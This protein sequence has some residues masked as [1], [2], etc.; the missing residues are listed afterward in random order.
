MKGPG[1]RLAIDV[2]RVWQCP[3]C[4]RIIKTDGSICQLR[5]DC[6]QQTQ[7]FFQFVEGLH[8]TASPFDHIAYVAKQRIAAVV[9]WEHM[10]EM[11]HT[12]EHLNASEDSPIAENEEAS[13]KEEE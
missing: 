1:F 2:R 7:P 5:C 8:K 13:R 6:D 11:D 10:D 3:S 9:G 4:E 12:K